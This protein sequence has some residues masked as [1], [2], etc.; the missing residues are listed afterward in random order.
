MILDGWRW[1]YQ[2]SV[3]AIGGPDGF[4]SVAAKTLEAA[5]SRVSVLEVDAPAF[6]LGIEIRG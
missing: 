4:A 2:L 6:L 3:K 1:G 5:C